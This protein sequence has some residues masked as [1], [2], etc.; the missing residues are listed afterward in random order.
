MT[1]QKKSQ[2]E[3][4]RDDWE[5]DYGKFSKKQDSTRAMEGLAAVAYGDRHY[6]SL[7]TDM[8]ILIDVWG[9]GVYDI[10]GFEITDK[11]RFFLRKYM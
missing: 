10:T 5:L 2:E 4:D 9:L 11:G 1:R 7:S 6:D 8:K 3:I